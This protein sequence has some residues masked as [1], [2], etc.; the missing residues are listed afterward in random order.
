[1]IYFSGFFLLLLENKNAKKDIEGSADATRVAEGRTLGSTTT[2][3]R[4]ATRLL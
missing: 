4:V 3:A 2:E 1:M